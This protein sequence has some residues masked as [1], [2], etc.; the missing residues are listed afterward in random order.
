ML[1]AAVDRFGGPVG[2]AGSV[3]VG[4]DVGGALLQGPAQGGDLAQRGRDAVAD[5]GDQRGHR[6]PA[7]CPVGVAVGGDHGLVD[8]PGHLDL[9]VVSGGEQG[10]D[11]GALSVGEQA[12]AGVQGPSGPVE[13]VP[14]A[15]AVTVQVLL[16]P[17][18]ALVQGVAGQAGDVEGV[19]HRDRVGQLLGGRGLEPGEPVHRDDLQPGPEALGLVRQ[20]RLEGLLGAAFDHVQ[21]PRRPGAVADRRQVDDHRHVLVP[22]AG[23]SP[24]VL[25]DPEDVHVLEPV[26]VVDQDPVA[27][28][29]DRVVGSVPRHR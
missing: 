5:R 9:D 26:R 2:G 23:V 6:R 21:Q 29:Q 3:E 8:A 28:G 25:I 19:H 12:G 22:T 27:F 17:A 15:A 11:A 10:L 7:P 14:C 16:D 1:E 20:P 18:P 13:R 4:Q 24:H